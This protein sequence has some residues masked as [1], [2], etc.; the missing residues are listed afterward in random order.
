MNE[1]DGYGLN[2]RRLQAV[3]TFFTQMVNDGIDI[4]V[5]CLTRYLIHEI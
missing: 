1:F 5:R 3:K 4:I 2:Y